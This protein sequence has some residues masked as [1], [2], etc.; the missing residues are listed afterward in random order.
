M[1]MR[2]N[3]FSFVF[4]GALG[5]S[6]AVGASSFN[7]RPFYENNDLS[8]FNNVSAQGSKGVGFES[9]GEDTPGTVPLPAV[10]NWK[11]VDKTTRLSP[12][13]PPFLDGLPFIPKGIVSFDEDVTGGTAGLFPGGPDGNQPGAAVFSLPQPFGTFGNDLAR[14]ADRPSPGQAFGT[15]ARGFGG[16]YG[17][18][19]SSSGTRPVLAAQAAPSI[20][21]TESSEIQPLLQDD[22]PERDASLQTVPL[23]ASGL[24]LI[25]AGMGLGVLARRKRNA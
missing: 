3:A 6:A 1:S 11:A 5:L 20:F 15:A 23:P 13:D 9:S 19:G 25:A 22:D 21:D 16:S 10:A 8:F 7:F 14:S 2:Q 24:M 18:D 12:F 4:M 17:S